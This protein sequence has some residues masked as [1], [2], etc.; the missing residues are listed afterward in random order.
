MIVFHIVIVSLSVVSFYYLRAGY[1][2][3]IVI[4]LV[5]SLLFQAIGFA[6]QGYL[7]PFFIVAFVV[8]WFYATIVSFFVTTVSKKFLKRKD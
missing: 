7:D 6:V 5:S 2:F 1:V 4:G 3:C 8:G